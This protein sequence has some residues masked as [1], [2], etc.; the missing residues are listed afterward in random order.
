[1]AR[2]ASAP[3][4]QIAAFRSDGFTAA[5]GLRIPFFTDSFSRAFGLPDVHLVNQIS[6]ATPLREERPYVP[7]VGLREVHYSR[8][9]LAQAWSVGSGPVRGLTIAP[10]ALGGRVLAVSGG[11]AFDAASGSRLGAVTGTDLVRFAQSRRQLVMAGGDRA[12]LF[13]GQKISP[14]VAD[15]L[16]PVADVAWLAGRF[17]YVCVGTD[18]FWYSD[19]NDAASVNGLSF[20][21]AESYPDATLAV[22]VL[23]EELVFFGAASVEFWQTTT[24]ANAPFQPIV[25]RGFQRGCAARDSVVFAD[26]ALFWVGD[27][28]VV[29]RVGAS[30]PLRVSSSSIEDKLR[31]CGDISAVSAWAATFEGHE[32]YVLT[33]PGVGSYAYDCSR[34]GAHE[35]DRGEWGEWRSW[36]RDAFRGQVAIRTGDVT[37]VGDDAVGTIWSMQVGV[38]Q[39]G[40]NPMVRQ[41]SAFIKVEEGTPRCNN[42][43]LHGVMGVGAT[44]D[45]GA[46]P[47]VEMRW[48]DDQGR[49][50]VDWR[51][52]SLGRRG[53]YAGRAFWQRL[54]CMRAPG[55]LVEVRCADPVN[56]VFSHLELNATRP[57]T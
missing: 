55:R 35:F 5:T 22:G 10:P 3:A 34:I 12:W 30:A 2:L 27:N 9:G 28:R 33:I 21:T 17:V 16:P 39:D 8:P 20:A 29:Y 18:T 51:K 53:R 45:P 44:V 14:I 31:Q 57:A 6:E 40:P 38:Y 41:A 50:F 7:V 11:A 43:V 15:A 56:V 46:D 23:N 24:D 26:N 25:G 19:V 37:Y 54:D 42:L 36:G 1:M 52:A 32:L 13:D 49:T 47:I 4:N 48:S